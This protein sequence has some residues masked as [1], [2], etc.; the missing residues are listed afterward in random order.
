MQCNDQAD[1]YSHLA[2]WQ[3]LM[4][5]HFDFFSL[6][7]VSLPS[8]PSFL[9]KAMSCQGNCLPDPSCGKQLE[10]NTRL[11]LILA[12][13]KVVIIVAVVSLHKKTDSFYCFV[14]L[15]IVATMCRHGEATLPSSWLGGL[16]V[17]WRRAA[18]L[19]ATL[20][21]QVAHFL[22]CIL[23][24]FPPLPSLPNTTNSTVT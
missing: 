15:H 6:H 14:R 18:P 17:G 11:R 3:P 2:S 19:A 4:T 21:F 23:P 16:H 20:Q 22:P 12:K 5:N 7:N 9:I 1:H 24:F 8:M 13:T 10:I